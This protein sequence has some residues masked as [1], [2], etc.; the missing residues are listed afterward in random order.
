MSFITI[1]LL[2][3]TKLLNEISSTKNYLQ[4]NSKRRNLPAIVI[5]II[6]FVLVNISFI[7]QN[8]YRA[9]I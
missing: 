3:E 2:K 5:K 4:K 8:Y 6:F 7:L 1:V 9:H